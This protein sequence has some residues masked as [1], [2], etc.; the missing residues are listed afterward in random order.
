MN[1]FTKTEVSENSCSIRFFA[2]KD[3][4]W[5]DMNAWMEA[6]WSDPAYNW[7]G[8]GKIGDEDFMVILVKRG[9]TQAEID[10]EN[11]S[12]DEDSEEDDE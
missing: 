11:E 1:P 12:D 2:K 5:A 7:R 4:T 6:K 10:A 9:K 3:A 8:F